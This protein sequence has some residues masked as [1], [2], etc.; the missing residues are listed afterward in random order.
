MLNLKSPS[1]DSGSLSGRA[2]CRQA[3]VTSQP[4]AAQARPW[5]TQAPSPSPSPS[6]SLALGSA[7]PPGPAAAAARAGPPAAHAGN[8]N[9][10]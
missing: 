3:E 10:I 5:A 1:L 6:D 9:F 4:E 7:G 2:R 8:L